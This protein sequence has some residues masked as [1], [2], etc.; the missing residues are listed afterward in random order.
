MVTDG[1]F[2]EAKELLAGYWMVDVET[3]QR[4]IEI[5]A[6]ASA[7]PGPEGVPLGTPIEV[8]QVMSAPAPEV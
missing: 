2:P 8:R 4:A 7:A 6:K 3:E 5:A 1:S